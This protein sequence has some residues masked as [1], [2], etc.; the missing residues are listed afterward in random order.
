MD[1]CAA[2]VT[3]PKVATGTA[4]TTRRIGAIEAS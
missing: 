1:K 3:T 4:R 2:G